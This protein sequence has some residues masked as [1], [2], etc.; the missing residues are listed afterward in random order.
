M[1]PISASPSSR[2]RASIASAGASSA[3][4]RVSSIRDDGKLNLSLREKIPA[5]IGPDSEKIYQKIQE[6]GGFLPLN[7][8]SDAGQIREALEM[9]KSQF[10]RAIGHLYKEGKIVLEEDGIRIAGSRK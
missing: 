1:K 4:A 8:R 7:D 2:H 5:Q 3:T 9:S 10:K 6:N